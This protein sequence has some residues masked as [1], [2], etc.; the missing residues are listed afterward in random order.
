MF[1]Q[2]PMLPVSKNASSC[3]IKDENKAFLTLI[4]SRLLAMKSKY[5]DIPVHVA[6]QITI[7]YV[8]RI[9]TGK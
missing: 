1:K 9:Y 3:F 8:N 4:F 2:L 6:L 5:L 7:K